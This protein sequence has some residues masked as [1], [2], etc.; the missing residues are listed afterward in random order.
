MEG[1]S[2]AP[3]QG[4]TSL[5]Q[6]DE[7]KSPATA[8]SQDVSSQAAPATDAV[9]LRL[10]QEQIAIDLA[11]RRVAQYMQRPEQLDKIVEHRRQI[12]RDKTAVDARI[13]ALAEQH[14]ENFKMTLQLLQTSDQ[15]IGMVQENFTN[16]FHYTDSAENA[17]DNWEAIKRINR[18]RNHLIN[19]RAYIDKIFTALDTA[20]DLDRELDQEDCNLLSIH[21]RN[22]DLET[23]RDELLYY[24]KDD[25]MQQRA[26]KTYF[27]D[28]D[29]LDLKLEQRVWK[30][31]TELLP[32]VQNR[33]KSVV[34]ALHIIER[35]EAMDKEAATST[36][37]LNT[38]QR[39]KNYREKAF[40]TITAAVDERFDDM[41]IEGD[42][43]TTIAN[44]R[45][46][47]PDLL[48]IKEKAVS[49]F[50]PSYNI[51]QF[52]IGLY[53]NRARLAVDSFADNSNLET[54]DIW[55][56]LSYSD[57]YAEY[58][59]TKLAV[60]PDQLN[61]PMLESRKDGLMDRYVDLI[62][63]KM[64][65]WCKNI[66]MTEW[67]EWFSGKRQ[68]PP[69]T[70]VDGQYISQV[71]VILFQMIDQQ[72]DVAHQANNAVFKNKVV[73]RC[74]AMLSE[75]T[76]QFMDAVTNQ[77]K[78]CISQ[79]GH[80]EFFLVYMMVI[81]N[82]SQRC[83]AYCEQLSTR[84]I[85]EGTI[86]EDTAE[87]M[88]KSQ[89]GFQRLERLASDMLIDV[90]FGDVDAFFV[91]LFTKSWYAN[92]PE[93]SLGTI[94]AT[95]EDYCSDF[96]DHVARDAENA[97][98]SAIYQTFLA[99]YVQRMFVK[100]FKIKPECAGRIK[101]E[102]DLALKFFQGLNVPHAK[103]KEET[104]LVLAEL[105]DVSEEMMVL[106]YVDL[107]TRQPELTL[108]HV[109]HVLHSRDDLSR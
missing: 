65:S 83:Q 63:D 51:L 9:R 61:P 3:A 12:L 19:T 69:D 104:V 68:D 27:Y 50:P 100:N 62:S 18:Q 46:I 64:K 66:I 48:I 55:L 44:F 53:H 20:K 74:G 95:L 42:C 10:L 16:M 98:L 91:P 33:P 40:Q 11:N 109:E 26:L 85:E 5:P 29:R 7:A 106:H 90:V 107:K 49:C 23:C 36:Y 24:V 57:Q 6:L 108:A 45:S 60:T 22:S 81:I 97:L 72:V 41:V 99:K 30:I 84:L 67:E 94:M 58:M 13:K 52:Y 103:E 54:A 25:H 35:E 43:R 31:L 76:T 92:T 1:V 34:S 28:V 105:C 2:I 37:Q 82:N 80:N 77:G 21:S 15:M 87:E 93:K 32:M 47:I 73:R 38:H 8:E 14:T 39:P 70:N 88:K 56:L 101:E 78:L 71:P 86:D 75:F 79:Q 4:S 102:M 89:K 96:K 59:E 17:I